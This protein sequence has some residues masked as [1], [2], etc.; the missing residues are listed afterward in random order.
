MFRWC[1]FCQKFLGE[2][3]PR[4]DHSI[5]HGICPVCRAKFTSNEELSIEK[6]QPLVNF[7]RGLRNSVKLNNKID[8]QEILL[9]ARKLGIQPTDLLIGLIQPLLYE[10]G[11]LYT[12]NE[13]TV[14][15]EHCFSLFVNELIDTVRREFAVTISSQFQK[16]DVLLVCAEGNYHYLGARFLETLIQQEGISVFAAFPSLRTED[17]IDL[18]IRSEVR[19]IGISLSLPDQLDAVFHIADK[20]NA[21]GLESP[22]LIIL[23]GMGLDSTS[24]RVPGTIIHDGNMQNLLTII[25]EQI[26]KPHT[27]VA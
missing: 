5:T 9:Q 21:L 7:F 18:A 15:A 17:I 2:I 20:L 8:V 13:I 22:P 24:L 10:I 27:S 16:F 3:Q 14:E 11:V 1:S 23:G 25:H 26:R 4:L 6:L 19:V 12:Q